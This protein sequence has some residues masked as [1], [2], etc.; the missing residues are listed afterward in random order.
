MK[1]TLR[2]CVEHT[3]L[4]LSHHIAF[5]EA[6]ERFLPAGSLDDDGELGSI[7]V[8]AT[9]VKQPELTNIQSWLTFLTSPAAEKQSQGKI[10]PLTAEEACGFIGCMVV[11]TGRPLLDQLDVVEAGSGRGRG[12]MQ[13]SGVRRTAYDK[14]RSAAIAKKIDPNS[15][16]WQ[17][18]YFAEE[19]AGKHDPPEGSLIGW[20]RIFEQRPTGMDPAQAAAYWTGSAATKTGYF[21]PGVPHLKRRQA[22]AQ[23]IWGL[24]QSKRLSLPQKP[25]A[26]QQE[27]PATPEQSLP[28]P[29]QVPWY[30]QLDSADRE[31]A[32]RMCFSSSNAMLLQHLKPGI[33][34]GPN[35]DDQYLRRVL[36][37]GDTTDS[38]AQMKALA[39]YGIK[40]KFIKTADFTMLEKQ[41]DRGIP[42][43]CG[44]L[45]RGPV[46]AP[47]GGG[48]W[49][50]VV[51]YTSTSLIV[52]DPFG[53]AD[54][55]AGTTISDVAR[56][57]KYSR[58]NFGSRWMVE[59]PKTGW[60]IIA[61]R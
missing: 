56:F 58:K 59:G 39:S 32:R 46:T 31:Q 60:A 17:Q 5:W 35:G 2:S 55:A 37:Y 49:L 13:Y 34:S 15:N 20:T 27:P 54:L 30:S 26:I 53:E 21:R 3:N 36:R 41:I 7:W 11:E 38:N 6:I 19:Y 28:N 42:V 24:V 25:P 18:Q 16:V 57:M 22:E 61:E 4:D 51:G 48:H 47:S 45:H 44:Y 8:S 12:A 23:R 43:P 40:A 14:A 33:L 50:I 29:L 10:K 1:R 9:P 52:H